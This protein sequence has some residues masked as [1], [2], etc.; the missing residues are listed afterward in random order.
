MKGLACKQ[1]CYIKRRFYSAVLSLVT[2]ILLYGMTRTTPD[3]DSFEFKRLFDTYDFEI[4]TYARDC[5]NLLCTNSCG[6]KGSYVTIHLRRG[7]NREKQLYAISERM[8]QK[9][10]S[11]EYGDN[12]MC[13]FKRQTFS[14]SNTSILPQ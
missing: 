4:G 8:L 9:D 7:G 1:W 6:V 5:E 2:L 12:M 13:D 14:K 11:V 3:L 10:N